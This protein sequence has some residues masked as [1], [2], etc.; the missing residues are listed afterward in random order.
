MSTTLKQSRL[1][2]ALAVLRIALGVVFLAHGSQKLFVFGFAGVTGAF[3]QMGLP[4]P[5]VIG[6][7]VAL[8]EFTGGLALIAGLLT[9]YAAAGLSLIML[10]AIL[11][12]HLAGGFFLPS[13]IEY[14]F[15][16]L[17]GLVTLILVGAGSY[18]VDAVVARRH[19]S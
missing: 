10:G 14:A 12:V 2:T 8:G 13:G 17:G 1:D 9:P 19:S 6:P 11:K 4:F 18:S 5:Q 15:A 16:L 3:T 7:L